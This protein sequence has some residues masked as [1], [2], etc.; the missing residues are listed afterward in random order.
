MLSHKFIK[1]LIDDEAT[2]AYPAMSS[3]QWSVE[4][5]A[6]HLPLGERKIPAAPEGK[7]GGSVEVEHGA[8]IL[9]SEHVVGSPL[10]MLLLFVIV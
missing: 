8:V 2:G 6:Y 3:C 5:P 10:K 9:I 7:S 4:Y 1:S